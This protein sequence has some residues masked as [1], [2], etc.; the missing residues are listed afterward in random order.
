MEHKVIGKAYPRIEAMKKALGQAKFT[1]DYTLPNMVYG[2]VLRSPYSHAK[3]KS[4]DKRQAEKIP[5][6]LKI[7][8]PLKQTI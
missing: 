3:V 7:L 1:D 2:M 8:L 6:V 5:G 4:I